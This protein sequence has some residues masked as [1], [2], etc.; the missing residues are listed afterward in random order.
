MRMRCAF[1]MNLTSQPCFRCDIR[2]RVEHNST[3]A[4]YSLQICDVDIRFAFTFAGSMNRALGYFVK[5][6]QIK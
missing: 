5:K 2:K 4:N 1:D 6:G 3:A